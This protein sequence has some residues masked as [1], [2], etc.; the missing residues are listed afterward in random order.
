MRKVLL[1]A[2]EPFGT[3]AVN[4]SALVCSAV[5]LRGENYTVA[6][7]ILP[8]EFRA[9]AEALRQAVAEER[10]ELVICMGQA[11]GRKLVTPERV[12]VNLMDARIPDNAGF[13]PD[14][15]PVEPAGP[16]AYFS[17][18]PVKAAVAAAVTAGLPAAVSDSAGTYVCNCIFY[19]LMHE[20]G[21]LPAN[22]AVPAVWGDFVHLPWADGQQGIDRDKPSLPV[23][24]MARTVEF[25]IEEMLKRKIQ[26]TI[27]TRSI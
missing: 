22:E 9:G 1:T 24:K 23:E 19:T 5:K 15:E 18:A 25:I 21:R 4:S 6:K 13:Q 17:N 16:A 12:A 14:E 7:R 10:P 26:N 27:C 11:G 3:D 20:I 2:F 8:V